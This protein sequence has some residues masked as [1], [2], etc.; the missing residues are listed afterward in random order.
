MS[1]DVQD[2]IIYSY[3][4]ITVYVNQDHLC[5]C[6]VV[7][8]F[9]YMVRFCELRISSDNVVFVNYLKLFVHHT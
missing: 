5:C 8:C 9:H 6:E 2:N 4:I 3:D 1:V 7:G